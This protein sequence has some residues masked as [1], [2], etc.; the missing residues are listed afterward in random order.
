MF[1]NY[2]LDLL[3]SGL[4]FFILPLLDKGS[5]G[6]EAA[7]Q[8]N[9]VELMLIIFS[10]NFFGFPELSEGFRKLVLNQQSLAQP[11][12]QSNDIQAEWVLMAS[13]A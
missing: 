6:I 12:C 8:G 13:S 10:R 11:A 1:L 3:S 5:S 4:G 2:G 7:G 9:R